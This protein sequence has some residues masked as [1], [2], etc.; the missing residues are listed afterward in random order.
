MKTILAVALLFTASWCWGQS[1]VVYGDPCPNLK[2]CSKEALQKLQEAEAKLV[3]DQK[4]VDD[5]RLFLGIANA[6][7]RIDVPAINKSVVAQF[8]GDCGFR[9]CGPSGPT[10]KKGEAITHG[11]EWTCADKSRILEHDEAEPPKY[12]CRKPQP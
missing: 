5:A 2:P 7:S 12:W 10:I 1:G 9:L 6:E 11:E 4:A 3:A 8:D